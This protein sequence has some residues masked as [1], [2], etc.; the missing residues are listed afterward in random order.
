[1][2]QLS[3]LNALFIITFQMYV[4]GHLY[5]Q[6]VTFYIVYVLGDLK[7]KRINVLPS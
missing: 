5:F 3:S 2:Y 4:I 1:M 7:T 6:Y